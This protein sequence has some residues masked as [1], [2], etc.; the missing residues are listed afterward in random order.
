MLD[1]GGFDVKIVVFLGF[2]LVVFELLVRNRLYFYV[3]IM[4]VFYVICFFM[5]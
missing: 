3:S 5:L 2:L 1:D 4:Y